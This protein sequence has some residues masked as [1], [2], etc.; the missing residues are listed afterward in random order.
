MRSVN[1]FHSK[2][3]SSLSKNVFNWIK[4]G[5]FIFR[6]KYFPSMDSVTNKN[7][8]KMFLSCFYSLS[9]KSIHFIVF[10][11]S[12]C[13]CEWVCNTG[14]WPWTLCSF[15]LFCTKVW[16]KPEKISPRS[17]VISNRGDT[18][19]FS[20]LCHHYDLCLLSFVTQSKQQPGRVWVCVC[21]P[22]RRSPRLNLNL[23]CCCSL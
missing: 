13:M 22:W 6:L 8:T 19:V 10:V 15:F 3:F 2:R 23:I 4:V 12:L 9:K 7:E 1:T 11:F 21:S 18:N 20:M 14:W 5:W 16:N 17:L